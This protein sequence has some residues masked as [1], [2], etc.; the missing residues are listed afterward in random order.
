MFYSMYSI[1][2]CISFYKYDTYINYLYVLLKFDKYF[3]FCN[4]IYL[5]IYKV[6]QMALFNAILNEDNPFK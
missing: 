3:C 2:L 1:A 4:V 5:F 6:L